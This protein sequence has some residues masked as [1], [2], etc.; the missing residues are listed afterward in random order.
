MP[1]PD[2]SRGRAFERVWNE[3]DAPWPVDTAAPRPFAA[4]LRGRSGPA[5]EKPAPKEKPEQDGRTPD[6][7]D[8]N[9][10]LE[11]QDEEKPAS[12]RTSTERGEAP[13]SAQARWDFESEDTGEWVATE[14]FTLDDELEDTWPNVPTRYLDD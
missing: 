3:T 6:D 4:H 1:H 2:S 8:G 11:R 13:A 7:R 10:E 9:E 14:R 5:Q 12:R